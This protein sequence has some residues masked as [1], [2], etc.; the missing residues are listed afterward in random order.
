MT[1]GQ[2]SSDVYLASTELLHPDATTWVYSEPLPSARIRLRSI[3]LNSKILVTGEFKCL[4]GNVQVLHN[5]EVPATGL[6][7]Y[8]ASVAT[9]VGGQA[10]YDM[11]TCW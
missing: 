1:G 6:G 11:M 10:K 3:I 2:G 9:G 8:D 4:L 7:K 5:Q